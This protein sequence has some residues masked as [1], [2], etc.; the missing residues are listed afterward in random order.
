MGLL[1][2]TWAR[3]LAAAAAQSDRPRAQT[4]L[5]RIES[6]SKLPTTGAGTCSVL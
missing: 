2:E 5:R 4:Y 6:S 3:Q 1:R